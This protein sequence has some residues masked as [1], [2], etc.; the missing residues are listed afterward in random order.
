[1]QS[2]LQDLKGSQHSS[3]S[4]PVSARKKT[5]SSE[6]DEAVAKIMSRKV[7]MNES[8]VVGMNFQKYNLL[9]PNFE[10]RRKIANFVSEYLEHGN[11]ELARDTMAEILQE[12]GVQKFQFIGYALHYAFSQ[13]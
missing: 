5:N 1:M 4:D 3:Q 8:N 13:D 2:L 9:K 11:P 7:S 10:V 12:T 6:E